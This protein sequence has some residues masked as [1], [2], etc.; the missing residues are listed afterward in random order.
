MWELLIS[1]TGATVHTKQFC[2]FFGKPEYSTNKCFVWSDQQ[3]HVYV[4]NTVTFNYA[5]PLQTKF[6]SD[7]LDGCYIVGLFNYDKN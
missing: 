4:R 5:A 3:D 1:H 7:N 2:H 6:G